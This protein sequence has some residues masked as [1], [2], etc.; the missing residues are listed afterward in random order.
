MRQF[1]ADIPGFFEL[2][3]GSADFRLLAGAQ[4]QRL[5][6]QG[7]CREI[8]RGWRAQTPGVEIL[9]V[10]I[11]RDQFPAPTLILQFTCSLQFRACVCRDQPGLYM[12]LIGD[13][14]DR[15]QALILKLDIAG[16]KAQVE[17][18][19]VQQVEK[20]IAIDTIDR[21]V[22]QAYRIALEAR[23]DDRFPGFTAEMPAGDQLS[24]CRGIN[25]DQVAASE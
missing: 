20:D 11:S 3:Q 18:T 17:L 25:F 13:H 7:V 16:D 12:P 2:L 5:A 23:L 21:V 6:R 19:P 1:D 9:A 22:V 24:L 10:N 4:A 14:I 15:V 8:Q